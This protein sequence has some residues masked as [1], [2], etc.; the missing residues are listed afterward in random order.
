M[1]IVV[2]GSPGVG[3]GTYTQDLVKMFNLVHISSG[4]LFREN[5]KNETE[6]GKKVKAYM[7]AGQLVPDEITIS[8]VKER[9][10]REDIQRKGFILDGFPRTVPQA[11]ALA[12]VT[13]LD[14]VVN[15]KAD[16]QVIITRLS[17]RIICRQCGRIFHKVNIPPKEEGVCD[18][19]QGELYQRDDDQ[20]EAVEKRLNAYKEQAGPLINYYQNKGLLKE[21]TINEDYGGHK[22]MIQERIL[23]LIKEA[24]PLEEESKSSES[25]SEGSCCCN[26]DQGCL[27]N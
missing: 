27:K 9:L 20:P 2:L 13:D 25:S 16:D 22:E 19:C 7:D 15:F 4:D 12:E 21:I 10:S 6:L 3:K 8:M 1:K 18:I 23:N 5:M 14:L 17:G 24:V 11:E 26:C